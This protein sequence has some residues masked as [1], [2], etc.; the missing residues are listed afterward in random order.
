MLTQVCTSARTSKCIGLSYIRFR[1]N[2]VIGLPPGQHIDRFTSRKC[3]C[4][5]I[6][7]RVSVQIGPSV[8]ADK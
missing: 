3:S 2:T 8:I 6:V 5:G 1:G 7:V 4:S